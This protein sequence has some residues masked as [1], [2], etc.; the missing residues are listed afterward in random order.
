MAHYVT[1]IECAASP[2]A[3][4]RYLADFSNAA[5]WDPT[6]TRV[7]GDAVGVGARFRVYLGAPG[8]ETTLDYETTRFEPGRLVEFRAQTPWLRSLDVIEFH[9]T[10]HGC[11]V[12][13]DADLRLLGLAKWVDLPAHWAFQV[14]GRRSVAGLEKALA[15]LV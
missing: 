10:N 14:S 8:L 9:P 1:S 4:F 11:R 13:Y 2:E 12:D 15:A 5:E 7:D 6:V 3:A